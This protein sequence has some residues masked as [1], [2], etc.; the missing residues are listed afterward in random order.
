VP[1]LDVTVND[2]SASDRGDLERALRAKG[3]P[4]S[5]QTVLD[6]YLSIKGRKP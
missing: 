5:D 2:I 4:V 3:R 6:L 1:L